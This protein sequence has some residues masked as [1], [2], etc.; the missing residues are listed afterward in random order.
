MF[1]NATFSGNGYAISNLY[2]ERSSTDFVGLFGYT[3]SNSTLTAIGLINV[4]INGQSRVGSLAGHNVG[5]ITNSYVSGEVEGAGERIGGLVGNNAANATI[6]NSCATASASGLGKFIGGLVG[7]NFQGTIT[8]SCATG[9]VSGSG[10]RV[11]GLVGFHQRGTIT[12]SYATGSVSGTGTQIG[13]LVGFN[14]QADIRNSYAT[15]D[16]KGGGS[17]SRIGGLV[18]ATFAVSRITNSYATGSVSGTGSNIGGLVGILNVGGTIS[19]SYWLDSSAS[20]G[21]TNVNDTETERTV[22]QLTSPTA[23]G[24]SST[25]AYHDWSPSVWDFGT[26]DQ[27]PVIKA[28]GSDILTNLPLCTLSIP[29][30]EED[31]DNVK[32]AMDIDKDND[33]LIEVCDI[34][35]LDAIRHQLDG[36]GYKTTAGATVIHTGCPG[37]PSRCKGYELARSLDFMDNDSYRPATNKA[38]YT[39]TTST[40]I[41]WEPIGES[42]SVPFRATFDGNDYT[43][44]NLMINQSNPN[45]SGLFGYTENSAITNLGLLDVN[46]SGSTRVGSLAG[47]SRGR[48]ENSYAT[49][50]VSATSSRVGGLV[51]LNGFIR[52]GIIGSI[53]DSYAAVSVSGTSDDLGGL[54]GS[55]NGTI[56]DSYATGNVRE[57]RSNIGGLAGFNSGTIA[58]IT[59]SYATGEV[60]GIN[61]LDSRSIGGLTGRNSATITNSYA[62]G[63]ALGRTNVGGLVGW[64]SSDNSHIVNSY[65]TGSAT[66]FVPATNPGGLVGNHARGTITNS[67]AIEPLTTRVPMEVQR[68]AEK[69]KLPIEPGTT[70]TDVYYNWN[71]DADVWDFGTSDQFPALKDSDGNLIPGQG[72]TLTG[73]SLRESLRE[74]EIPRLRTTSS[75]IFGV[76]TNNYVVT[77]FLREGIT[78]DSIVLRL[79][80]YNPDAEIQIFREGDP[81]DYFAGKMSG[82]ESLPIVVGAETKL[83]IRVNE[84]DTDYTLTFRVDE[85]EGIQI[86]VKVFLEGPLQ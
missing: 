86:R 24:A 73:S 38:T 47:L 36:T 49:G 61:S 11:G 9:T 58:S 48:I 71:S 1:F 46:I 74:L 84:P 2:I 57:G 3:G 41:G 52:N 30:D 69:L 70:Q 31:K 17:S 39:V 59:R 28:S 56:T 54:V 66:G 81:T 12:R 10:E 16:V 68:T 23:P 15:G 26:S 32:H 43:I 27:F 45:V 20:R 67:Y 80:A 40:D 19:S 33:G 42:F 18:G 22:E 13:G 83:T 60:K 63:P 34:E 14:N 75:Q 5:V 65:A 4:D 8:N 53:T 7:N 21:G 64:N 37:S 72:T 62:T 6:T 25:D 51:G 76:S 79:K 44:S 50:T 85:L 77:I 78:T 35:G 29:D 55:N 82:D